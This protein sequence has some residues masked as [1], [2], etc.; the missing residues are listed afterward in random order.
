[1]KSL[2]AGLLVPIAVAMI[3]ASIAVLALRSVSNDAP[4]AVAQTAGA[5][6]VGSTE[7]DRV[8]RLEMS[9][10]ATAVDNVTLADPDPLVDGVT[11][12][13]GLNGWSGP[14]PIINDHFEIELSVEA[15][16]KLGDATIVGDLLPGDRIGGTYRVAHV[17]PPPEVPE[18]E[19]W[20]P[21]ET[22]E[23]PWSGQLIPPKGPT[24]TGETSQGGSVEITFS[25]GLA[26]VIEMRMT[27]PLAVP[28]CPPSVGADLPFLSLLADAPVPV[29]DGEFEIIAKEVVAEPPPTYEFTIAGVLVSET[30]A[31]GTGRVRILEQPECNTGVLTWTASVPTPAPTPTAGPGVLPSGGGEPPLASGNSQVWPPV[32]AAASGLLVVVA[33][34][35][36]CA[37]PHTRR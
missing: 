20:E 24:F 23:M 19:R 2:P 29:T 31:E 7:D 8:L 12:G 18:E 9:G 36:V 6:Y 22:G 27:V 14:W 32:L 28:G 35:L 11:C 10:D 17:E 13:V 37:L 33:A 15:A 25:S 26:F 30:E 4:A 34:A 1:V 21:C 16:Y 3:V 5:E